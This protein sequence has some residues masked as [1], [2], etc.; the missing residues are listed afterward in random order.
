[1]RELKIRIFDKEINAGMYWYKARNPLRIVTNGVILSF[2]KFFPSLRVKNYLL[3]LTGVTVGKNVCIAP[4]VIDPIFP[5]LIEIGDNCIIGW[6]TT[7]LTH[8]IMD[9]EFRTGKVKIGKNTTIG[10]N[11]LILPGI[12]IGKNVIVGACSLV[13][14]D[15]HDKSTVAGVPTKKIHIKS[16]KKIT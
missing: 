9:T 11:T 3:R 6:G 12:H 10:A 13:D 8:E 7:I 16:H 4:S 1:M 5:E 15:I 2:A 14:K